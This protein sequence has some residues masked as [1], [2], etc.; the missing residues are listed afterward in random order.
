VDLYASNIVYM[1]AALLSALLA[2]FL[3]AWL[4]IRL[5]WWVGLI[6]YPGTA[7]HKVHTAPTPLGGGIALAAALTLMGTAFGTLKD[8]IILATFLSGGI[9]FAF[10]LWDDYKIIP[11]RLKLLGQVMAAII[12]IWMGVYVRM[13]ESPEF[14]FILP[15]RW[16]VYLDWVVT[17]L[18]MIGIT[19]AF[20]FVDSMDGLAVGLGGLAAAFFMLV[21][22][23]A[24][25]ILLSR[26]SALLLG[27]CFGLYFFNSPPAH[28]FLG[29]SGAQT[30]GFILATLGIVYNPQG[31]YQTS[32][33]FVPVL[34]LGV[35]IFD[36]CLVFFSRLRRRRP[37]YRSAQDHT[38]HRLLK[39]GLG[40]NR[41]V[42]GM[43]L[44]ALVLGCLAVLSL[45]QTPLVANGIFVST[46][47]IGVVCL[48][49]L[50]SKRFRS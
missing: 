1:F 7:A 19:N 41:V 21:T 17:V 6:D 14:F 22:L 32:S 29:D 48:L 47:V 26:H 13:F 39:L 50:D 42:L 8:P 34:L 3:L 37:F 24:G 2:V 11:P 23:G 44:I 28:L 4:S 43:H 15:G 40:S 45:S 35:P 30:L 25:Q 5:S 49:F 20:N 18:W 16:K 12:L 38:Y 10:G 9:V 46:I 27:V 36:M 31:A 33:W